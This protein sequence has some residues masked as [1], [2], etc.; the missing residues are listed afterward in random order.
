MCN[1]IDFPAT[2]VVRVDNPLGLTDEE[3]Q[4]AAENLAAY[5]A[6]QTAREA[7][8]RGNGREITLETFAARLEYQA[9]REQPTQ[10]ADGVH[11]G[12]LF[13]GSWGYE[14]TNVD[15]FQVIALKGKH[16][17]IIARIAGDYIGG[18]C[19]SGN[20]RPC[21]DEFID[22]EQY[23]VRTKLN[24]YYNPPRPSMKHPTVSSG[25]TLSPITDDKEVGYSSYY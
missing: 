12:D 2:R 22:G 20:V 24:D 10:N 4:Q 3:C 1:I 11:I 23:T 7:A 18:F 17:A 6:E 15:F 21:R 5:Y 8:Y 16:T 25:G 9:R 19:M 13:Y 14:Q